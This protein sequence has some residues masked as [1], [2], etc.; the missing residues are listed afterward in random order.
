MNSKIILVAAGVVMLA[1]AAW[2]MNEADRKDP[3]PAP[4]QAVIDQAGSNATGQAQQQG[5]GMVQENATSTGQAQQQSETIAAMIPKAQ[6]EIDKLGKGAKLIDFGFNPQ[7]IDIPMLTL[8]F[9]K[10]F[11][12]LGEADRKAVIAAAEKGLYEFIYGTGTEP[13]FPKIQYRIQTEGEIVR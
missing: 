7:E 3:V 8:N 11:L 10:N 4:E 13:L 12:D 1:V 2:F 5:G 6:A 9:Q